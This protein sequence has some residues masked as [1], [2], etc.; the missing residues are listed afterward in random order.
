[1]SEYDSGAYFVR[2][3]GRRDRNRKRGGGRSRRAA[4]A[5]ITVLL[6]LTAAICALV[7]FLPR[8]STVGAPAPNFKGKTF[9]MLAT[10][11]STDREQS[12]VMAQ[13]AVERGGAGYIYNDGEYKI[14]AAVYDKESDAKTL[15][16]VNENSYY[17]ALTVPKC[18]VAETDARALE[19]LTGEWYDTVRSAASELQRGNIAESQAEH[20]VASACLRL[21]AFSGETSSVLLTAALDVASEYDCPDSYSI[22]SYLHYVHVRA[23]TLAAISLS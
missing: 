6:L 1:M 4:G 23:I 20:A 17:F 16:S 5:L 15:A 3:G 19:Y 11:R 18:N 21:K 13:Y 7:A 8:L 14:I 10:G 22:L 9:Y 2:R 12:H